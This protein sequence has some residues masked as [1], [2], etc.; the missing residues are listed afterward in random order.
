MSSPSSPGNTQDAFFPRAVAAQMPTIV[1]G[2]GVMLTD[3]TGRHL[4][5]VCSGPFLAGLG[6]G[7]ERVLA[8]GDTAF[9]P[10]GEVHGTWN[11]FDEML[12]FLAI[13]SPAQADEPSIVD[14]SSE[15]PWASLR[16]S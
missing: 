2:R 8:P 14:M 1:A 10:M 9:I 13:L 5:D 4:I 15:E 7:N 3:D 12:V 6:Q 16:G 11:P